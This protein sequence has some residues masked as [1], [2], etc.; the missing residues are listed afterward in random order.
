LVGFSG[1]LLLAFD[2]LP[3]LGVLA[4]L[5]L[6][7]ASLLEV[8]F[9]MLV[10]QPDRARTDNKA[11]V[12]FMSLIVRASPGRGHVDFLPRICSFN[13][14]GGSGAARPRRVTEVE[15][16]RRRLGRPAPRR[17]TIKKI[18]R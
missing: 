18:P 5:G 11:G 8:A 16:R 3:L 6:D 10:R 2:A 9:G 1:V 15:T 4:E 17:V 7:A 13:C 12:R 14:G